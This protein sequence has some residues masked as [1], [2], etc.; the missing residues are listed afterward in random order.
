MT[1]FWNFKDTGELILH[2]WLWI[3]L[4]FAIGIWCGWK[5]SGV[6]SEE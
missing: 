4:A 2:N 6:R 5:T 3:A 1:E